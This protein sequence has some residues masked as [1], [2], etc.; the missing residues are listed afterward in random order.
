MPAVDDPLFD[1]WG[2]D[3]E[4]AHAPSRVPTRWRAPAGPP[5]SLPPRARL[6]GTPGFLRTMA[7]PRLQ[8]VALRLHM[9][10]HHAV[11]E[12]HLD[13]APPLIRLTVRPWRGPWSEGQ[14]PPEG[15]LELVL[16]PGAEGM[17]IAESWIGPAAKEPAA[18]ARVA[19]AKFGAAWLEG[20][21]FD[22]LAR[23]LRA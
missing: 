10:R 4:N 7:V 12:D 16:E 14:E 11:V 6:A 9:A 3:A 20:Q 18:L 13:G 17:V 2:R 21:V 15:T 22:F 8:E 19:P 1:P 23:L 5:P